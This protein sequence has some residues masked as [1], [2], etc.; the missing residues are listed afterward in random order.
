MQ[1]RRA[2]LGHRPGLEQRKA[3]ALLERRVV[4]RV[5]AGAEAEAQ[6]VLAVELARPAPRAASPASRRGSGRPSRRLSRTLC[7]QVR[8]WKR[9]SWTMQPPE[10]IAAIDENASAFMWLSGS[11]VMKRSTSG[12]H[13]GQLAE[14]EVPLAGAQEVAVG[15]AAALRLAGRARGVEQRALGAAADRLARRGAPASAPPGCGRRPRGGSCRA[16]LPASAAAARSAPS[17][18]RQHD[19]ERHLAVADEVAPF[20][21]R[22]CRRGSARC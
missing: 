14:A 20:G 1:A 4:A 22:A 5:D 13:L 8:G 15:E 21:R 7:H 19:G 11:G 18:R 6:L 3:E 2:G 17:R 9:S 10:R 16:S 12:A